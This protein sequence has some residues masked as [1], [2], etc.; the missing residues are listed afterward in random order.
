MG[1]CF[2]EH[3]PEQVTP[4][5][6]ALMKTTV[7]RKTPALINDFHF[8]NFPIVDNHSGSSDSDEF[9]SDNLRSD[10][11]SR[12]DDDLRSDEDFHSDDGSRYG[13]RYDYN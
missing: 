6:P 2:Q 8:E 1:E 9:T 3:L 7:Q 10:D 5:T 12:S 4:A 13:T 11:D